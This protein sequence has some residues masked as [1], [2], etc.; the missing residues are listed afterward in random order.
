MTTVLYRRLADHYLSAIRSGA[1]RSGDRMP[2][3]RRLMS[4]HGV[5]LSTALQTCRHLEDQGWLEARPRTG[6]FVRTPR[7]AGLPPVTE[8]AFGAAPIDPAAYVGI[9]AHVSDVLARGERAP[10]DVNLALAVLG[11]PLYPTAALQRLMQGQLRRHPETL[12]TMTRHHGH[13]SLRAALARHALSRGVTI[14]PDEVVV[15]H[16]CIEAVN[17]ALRAVTQPGDTVAVESP[18][19]YGLLQV[20]ESLGLKALEMPTSP[21]TGLS[22]DALEF[23]LQ[24]DAVAGQE[25]PPDPRH[26]PGSLAS[27]GRIRA[28]VCMPTLHNPLGCVMP[29][30]HKQRL[31]ELCVRHDV[32][33]IED[34]IYG[35]MGHTDVPHKPA[36]AWDRTGHVIYCHSLNKLL[37]PGLRLG[38]M[39]PGRWQARVEMLKYTQSRYGEELPQRTIAEFMAGPGMARHLNRMRQRL[40]QQREQMAEAVAEFFPEGTRLCLPEG[41]MLLWVHLPEGGSGDALF[42]AALERGIKI[43]P[44][45]LFANSRRFDHCIR[46]SCG[47]AFTSEVREAVAVLG[48]LA[49]Q[50]TPTAL[51]RT[52]SCA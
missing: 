13:A 38:W 51:I 29:D 3:V 50:Q 42:D 35:D 45:S 24:Q 18:T 5:S 39:L 30:A 25:G 32:A 6:Y 19:F 7:R 21:T 16:G 9:H 17:L 23:A 46:L 1:L 49:H 4:D 8:S 27:G 44:G 43:A 14:A 15:T 2:S 22:L 12:T 11:E 26:T 52:R 48:R 20:L 28:V 37:A 33:L 31:V 10:V 36:K 47:L 40:R 41:G 34:D